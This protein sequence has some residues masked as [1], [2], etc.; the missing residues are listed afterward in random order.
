MD[1]N[2]YCYYFT[3]YFLLQTNIQVIWVCT[4]GHYFFCVYKCEF[5]SAGRVLCILCGKAPKQINYLEI[6]RWS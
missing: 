1:K 6:F 3:V 5:F 4:V 2:F